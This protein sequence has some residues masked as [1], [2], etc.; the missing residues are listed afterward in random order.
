MGTL[1]QARPDPEGNVSALK[2]NVGECHNVAEVTLKLRLPFS[3]RLLTE[4]CSAANGLTFS[5]KN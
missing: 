4:I 2:Q 3:S 1:N 5:P